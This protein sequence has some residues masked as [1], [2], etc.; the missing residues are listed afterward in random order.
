ME[1]WLFDIAVMGIPEN[2]LAFNPSD[3]DKM[4]NPMSNTGEMIIA[5]PGTSDTPMQ[6]RGYSMRQLLS[7]LSPSPGTTLQS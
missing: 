4:Q 1:Q 2:V 5:W 7:G 6:W 3:N